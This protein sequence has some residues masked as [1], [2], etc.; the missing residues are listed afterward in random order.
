MTNLVSVV[1][2]PPYMEYI[3]DSLEYM[4]NDIRDNQLLVR[5]K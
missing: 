4:L 2:L 5:E 3:E 1:C